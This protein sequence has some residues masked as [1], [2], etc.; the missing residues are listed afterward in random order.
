MEG[1][2]NR[3][4]DSGYVPAEEAKKRTEGMLFRIDEIMEPKS[5][6]RGGSPST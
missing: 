5:F 4:L 3:K 1:L 2:E 6:H